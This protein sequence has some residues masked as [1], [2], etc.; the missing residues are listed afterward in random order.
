MTGFSDAKKAEIWEAIKRDGTSAP[1]GGTP[2]GG[3]LKNVAFFLT[4]GTSDHS[5]I[6][7]EMALLVGREPLATMGIPQTEVQAGRYEGE[8]QVFVNTLLRTGIPQPRHAVAPPG[9]AQGL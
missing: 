3:R 2:F 1:Y 9:T 7:K 8:V 6:F 5:A 4:D